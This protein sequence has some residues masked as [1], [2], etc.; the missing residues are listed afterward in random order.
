M[1][2][3]SIPAE[4]TICLSE[5]KGSAP[6]STKYLTIHT[7]VIL[8]RGLAV[9][10]VLP[11]NGF[12]EIHAEGPI[13]DLPLSV[14]HAE[15]YVAQGQVSTCEHSIFT[16]L[17]GLQVHLYEMCSQLVGHTADIRSFEYLDM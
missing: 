7:A 3:L 5:V 8:G 11:T 15:I 12:F 1:S 10:E 4:K 14:S 2:S 6:F 9:D 17:L 13:N 16:T